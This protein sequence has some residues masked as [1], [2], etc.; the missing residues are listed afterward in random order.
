M[1]GQ[2]YDGASS[3][4]GK[5]KGVRAIVIESYPALA[6][7]VHC[8]IVRHVLNLVLVKSCAIPEIHSTFDLIGD[9]A[10]FF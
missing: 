6:I 2:G 3:M 1:I 10:S 4:F 7:Y 9:I 5:E 8:S